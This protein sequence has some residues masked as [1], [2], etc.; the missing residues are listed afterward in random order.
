MEVND[1]EGCIQLRG[2]TA[3]REVCDNGLEMG[4]CKGDWKCI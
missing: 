1:A 2:R 4:G 3:G